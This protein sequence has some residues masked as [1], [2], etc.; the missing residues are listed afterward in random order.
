MKAKKPQVKSP[1]TKATPK[2]GRK[3]G[4]PINAGGR[5]KNYISE[6]SDSS[7][8]EVTPTQPPSKKKKTTILKKVPKNRKC[9][10]KSDSSSSELPWD[11]DKF[12]LSPK[13]PRKVQEDSSAGGSD[14]SST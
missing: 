10:D 1:C 3:R 9:S 6:E 7:I 5:K 14:V 11:I 4:N 13:L 8:E 12:G 2:V